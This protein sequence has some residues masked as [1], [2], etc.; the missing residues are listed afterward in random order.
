MLGAALLEAF[1]EQLL[2][3]VRQVLVI[4]CAIA[5]IADPLWATPAT[6]A[7]PLGT[8]VYA[9]RAHIGASGASL[10]STL[11]GGDRLSTE[12][13][14]GVQVRTAAARLKLS[15]TSSA[16]LL[17]EASSAAA[18]LTAGMATF[19]TA[20][21]DAFALHA[22]EATIKPGSNQPTVAEVMILGKNEIYVRSTRGTLVCSVAGEERT[23]REGEAYR[24]LLDADSA[25]PAPQGPAG[26]GGNNHPPIK[27]GRNRAIYLIAGAIAALTIYAVHEA[28]E[29]PDRP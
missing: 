27:G 9:D 13:Q 25:G 23:I 3:R 16:I 19:S 17:E 28:L 10:G 7:S 18:I 26:A 21:R 14:G 15:A 11:F 1:V 29:S 22:F 2:A 8:I 20:N 24:V 5:L 6:S 12:A 4:L